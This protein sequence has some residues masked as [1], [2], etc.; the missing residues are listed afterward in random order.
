MKRKCSKCLISKGF[1][2]FP[3]NRSARHNI[4]YICKDCR[5]IDYKNWR[6]SETG[7][8]YFERNAE[9]MKARQKVRDEIKAG[10]IVKKPCEKCGNPK[11]CGHHEDYSKPLEIIWLCDFHHKE[12]HEMLD[13]NKYFKN[14][15][16]RVFTRKRKDGSFGYKDRKIV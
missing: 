6:K 4:G 2:E 1:S 9:K 12:R 14:S 13:K 5:K 3:T 8:A 11:A 15:S 16:K 7:K 10:R